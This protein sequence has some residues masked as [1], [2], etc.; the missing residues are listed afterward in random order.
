MTLNQFTGELMGL[1]DI[2]I[3]VQTYEEIAAIRMR[4]I[5]SGVLAN[6]EFNEGIMEI[7]QELITAYRKDLQHLLTR[8]HAK[9]L[10]DL[11]LVQRNGKTLYVLLSSNVGLYGDIVKR[12]FNLF[13]SYYTKTPADVLIIGKFGRQFFTELHP[14]AQFRYVEFPD[15]TIDEPALKSLLEELIYYEQILVFHGQYRSIAK[16]DAVVLNVYG[17]DS[18]PEASGEHRERYLFEPSLEKIVTFFEIELF[19]SIFE[20][21]LFEMQ[22]AKLAGRLFSLD[23]AT[24]NIKHRETE[25]NQGILRMKHR[26]MNGKQMQTLTGMKLWRR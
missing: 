3:L 5:R 14:D 12:A 2:K 16:Q 13:N 19:A 9:S 7:F 4:K 25:I 11:S 8:R 23:M 20:Q 22:L 10:A 17:S 18:L 6:R 15:N 21:S 24:E 1:A 26:Q